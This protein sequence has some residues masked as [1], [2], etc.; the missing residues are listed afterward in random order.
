MT[1]DQTIKIGISRCL[2]GESVRY[3]GGHQHYIRAL[4]KHKIGQSITL[5]VRR[6]DQVREVTVKLM[7]IS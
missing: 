7:D 4:E 6:G 2:I 3:G 1:L 5:R